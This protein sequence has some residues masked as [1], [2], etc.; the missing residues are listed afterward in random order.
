MI[1]NQI[2]LVFTFILFF[3]VMMQRE[4]FKQGKVEQFRQILEEGSSPGILLLVICVLLCVWFLKQIYFYGSRNKYICMVL[5][6]CMVLLSFI[7]LEIEH[8]FF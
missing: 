6:L 1:S 2:I 3:N 5:S 4:Y 7:I 8:I